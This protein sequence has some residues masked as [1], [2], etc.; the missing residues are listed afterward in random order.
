MRGFSNQPFRKEWQIV[1]I[2]DLETR[3]Q[4]GDTVDAASL[5]MKGLIRKPENLIKVLGKGK[6]TIA[7]NISVDAVSAGA[8]AKIE[9][10]GGKVETP[11]A[12][13]SASDA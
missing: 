2:G 12:V 3:F 6:L 9:A 7:L 1:N 11:T 8:K 13:G 10:A 4:A 5:L